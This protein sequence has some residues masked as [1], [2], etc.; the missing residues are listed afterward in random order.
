MA[1][2]LGAEQDEMR[3]RDV[4]SRGSEAPPYRSR[5]GSADLNSAGLRNGRSA[6]LAAA[7]G[8][9]WPVA[10]LAQDIA[11][12]DQAANLAQLNPRPASPAPRPGGSD[13]PYKPSYGRWSPGQVLPP[14]AGAVAIADYAQF[15]LRRP[16]QGYSWMQCDGDF[17]LA[18][19]AG[20]IF[21]V[22]PGGGR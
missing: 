1:A 16:P 20:L 11:A 8:L 19:D 3:Q 2:S 15:H 14:S 13:R 4:F 12:G 6:W 18:N 21:E 22:I 10:G 5:H 9:L 17:I 7:V